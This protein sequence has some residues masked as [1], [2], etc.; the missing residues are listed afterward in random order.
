MNKVNVTSILILGIIILLT[1]FSIMYTFNNVNLVSLNKVKSINVMSVAMNNENYVVQKY[2]EKYINSNIEIYYPVTKYNSL[3]T[4]INNFIKDVVNSFKQD[5]QDDRKYRLLGNFDVFKYN[6]YI[7]FSFHIMEDFMGAHP[8]TVIYTI[9]YD[10]KNDKIINIDLLIEMN[11]N[12]LNILSKY[13]FESLSKNQKIKKYKL[14]D[15][16]KEGTKPNKENFKNFVLTK[17]GIKILFE[18]YQVAPYAYGEF[19]VTIPYDK[20]NLTFN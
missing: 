3:N 18:R 7:S 19:S 4:Y 16:L 5:V 2:N 6:N 8:N 1:I 20:L 15:F 14:E 9:N 12:I 10:I 13:S 17:E 11:N